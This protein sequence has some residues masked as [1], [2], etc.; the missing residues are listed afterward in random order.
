MCDAHHE[1]V[2]SSGSPL[3]LM[4]SVSKEA[5]EEVKYLP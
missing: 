4:R 2:S 5:I 3:V 1:C